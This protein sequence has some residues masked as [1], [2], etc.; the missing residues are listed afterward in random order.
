MRKFNSSIILTLV[1]W[2]FA[3]TASFAQNVGLGLTSPQAKLHI[4]GNA[5]ISQLIIDANSTQSNTNPLIR[6]RN[7]SGSELL[8]ISSDDATNA[9]FGLYA[10]KENIPTSTSGNY[11]TFLG[12]KAGYSNISGSNNTAAGSTCLYYNSSGSNNTAF[13]LSAMY[14]TGSGSNNTAIGKWTLLNNSA[15]SDNAALG[16][17]AL[18]YS[19]LSSNTGIGSSAG[20]DSDLNSSSTYIGYDA[21]NN[22][23]SGYTNSTALGNGSRMTA[24]NQVRIGNS[25]ITSIGGYEPWT[26]ISDGRFKKDINDNVP[27]LEFITRLRPVTYYL[28]VHG[29]AEKLNEDII[30]ARNPEKNAAPSLETLG[31]R[32][33]KSAILKTGF[34]AQEVQASAKEI[35]YDFSGLDAPENK[36]DLYGLRYSQFVVPLTKAIQEQQKMIED[37]QK[38]IHLLR[39]LIGDTTESTAQED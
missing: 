33:A 30:D 36:S 39:K 13:G 7:A 38:E 19:T 32:D 37:L 35:G 11:N 24:S 17:E 14:F 18:R 20:T 25:S 9:F 4:K 27:G 29:L 28:N 31:A 10:G 5:N 15:G 3:G 2:H 1:C 22:V 16:F 8:D 21:D 26:D 34:I 12:A 6:L 23:I